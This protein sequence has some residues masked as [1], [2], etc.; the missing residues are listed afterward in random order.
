MKYLREIPSDWLNGKRV[1]VRAG[2]N[3]PIENGHIT[4]RYRLE[5]ALTTILYLKERGARVIVIS[6]IGREG[7]TLAPVAKALCETCPVSFIPEIIGSHAQAAIDAMQPGDVVML[8]NLRRHPGEEGNDES[9][10][11]ALA[12]YADIFV[13]DAFETAHRAHASVVGVPQ[14][15][16][17]YAGLLFADEVRNLESAL[18]PPAHSLCIMGGAKF[19]TKEPLIEK[20]LTLYEYVYIGGALANDVFKARGYEV[21]RSR[22]SESTPPQSVMMNPRM[23]VPVDVTAQDSKRG[24]RITTPEAVRVDE[25]IVDIGPASLKALLPHIQAASFILWN[26]PMGL[27][28][29]G[30]NVWTEE[31]ARAIAVSTARA[32]VGGGDTVAAIT[33][34]G[35]ENEFAFISTGGGAMLEYL[36]LGTLP[37]ID[38]LK[39]SR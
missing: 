34:L 1:L 32:I 24:V 26:G 9:F 16:D 36:Q 39:Y 27:Y 5:Q 17:S 30:F 10:S 2:L 20:F 35:L 33:A 22:V 4:N 18:K 15:L 21:G 13:Q 14:Y 28:E 37:A 7:E 12:S 3:V 6:H 19:E 8:E 25:K 31:M 11:R 23:L 38:A 29:E